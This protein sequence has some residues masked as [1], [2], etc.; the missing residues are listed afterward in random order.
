MRNSKFKK[1]KLFTTLALI[2]AGTMALTS[3]NRWRN[4]SSEKKAEYIKDHINDELELSKNQENKLDSLIHNL[5]SAK[6]S[7]KKDKK[8]IID[9]ISSQITD[10]KFDKEKILSHYNG[11]KEKM[12]KTVLNLIDDTVELHSALSPEQ[13]NTIK[14]KIDKHKKHFEEN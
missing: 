2:S 10:E 9:L 7:L 8:Q 12:D 13:K 1:I 14:E 11:I 6:K 3:C 5:L 4:T